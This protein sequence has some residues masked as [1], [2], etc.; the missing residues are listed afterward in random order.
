MFASEVGGL[1]EIV[2]P[3][4]GHLFPV[5]DHKRLQQLLVNASN[6]RL[7]EMG[8]QGRQ[9][10]VERYLIDRTSEGLLSIYGDLVGVG[11]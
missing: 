5:G 9:R 7:R 2:T 6:E 3:E 11:R 8:R 4:T 10:F 1:V